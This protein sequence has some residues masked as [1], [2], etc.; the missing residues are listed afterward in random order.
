MTQGRQ[1]EQ[2]A[3]AVSEGRQVGETAKEEARRVAA[4]SREEAS[5]LTSEALD[6]TREVAGEAMTRARR[7]ADAGLGQLAGTIREMGEQL[8]TMAQ[9]PSQSDTPVVKI[10]ETAGSWMS[11]AGDQLEQRGVD[12]L[13][14]DAE[15]FARRRPWMFLAAAAGLGLVTGRLIR[16]VEPEQLRADGGSRAQEWRPAPGGRPTTV[17]PAGPTGPTTLPSTALEAEGRPGEEGSQQWP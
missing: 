16:A 8:R 12:G 9:A 14:N 1:R 3:Q 11:T 4:R 2:A 13:W 15:S 6:R 17:P 7:Q 10:A 5:S